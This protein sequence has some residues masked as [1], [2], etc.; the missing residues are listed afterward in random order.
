MVD[1]RPR[2]ARHR[3]D[4]RRGGRRPCSPRTSRPV[5]GRR[6]GRR[7]AP[8]R[9]PPAGELYYGSVDEFVEQFI[10]PVFSR[11]VGEY[12]TG[13][14]VKSGG[15]MPKPPSASRPSGGLGSTH[16]LDPATCSCAITQTTSSP[17][18]GTP[19][20]PSPKRRFFAPGEPHPYSK[21]PAGFFPDVR[22]G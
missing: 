13:A 2:S 19:D 10:V 11:C 4:H 15:A 3:S 21:P 5:G 1:W 6:Q 17:Y 7:G 12:A 18:S 8:A 9:G 20:D 16:G 14:G 22:S